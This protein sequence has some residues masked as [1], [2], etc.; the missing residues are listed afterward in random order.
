MG[1]YFGISPINYSDSDT[2]CLYTC[3]SSFPYFGFDG[4]IAVLI[5]SGAGHCL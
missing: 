3:S 2:F 5:L 4:M 1:F